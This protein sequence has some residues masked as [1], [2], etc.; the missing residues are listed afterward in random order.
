MWSSQHC[1]SKAVCAGSDLPILACVT[2]RTCRPGL[3][4]VGCVRKFALFI[5]SSAHT[6]KHAVV[7]AWNIPL[8][9]LRPVFVI[10]LEPSS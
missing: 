4:R 6:A 1:C 7:D 10:G 9:A 2:C 8:A 5:V 3:V